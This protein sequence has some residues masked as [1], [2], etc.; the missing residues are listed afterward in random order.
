MKSAKILQQSNSDRK[1]LTGLDSVKIKYQNLKTC[2]KHGK[3]LK[4]GKMDT[5]KSIVLGTHLVRT[6]VF[7]FCLFGVFFFSFFVFFLYFVCVC[8]GVVVVVCLVY[9]YDVVF[10]YFLLLLLLLLLGWLGY[11]C[12]VLLFVCCCCSCCCSSSNVACLTFYLIFL[13]CFHTPL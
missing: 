10:C 8:W 11:Y 4:K 1:P 13:I 9:L 5:P 3:R 2:I 7:C 6:D 12:L